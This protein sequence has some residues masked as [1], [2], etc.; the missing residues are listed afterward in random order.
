M[1]TYFHVEKVFLSEAFEQTYVR[2]VV[3]IYERRT[4]PHSGMGA[5]QW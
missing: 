4:N 2:A 1:K 5:L 3:K